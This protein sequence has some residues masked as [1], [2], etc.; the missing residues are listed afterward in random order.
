MERFTV[1][2]YF[3]YN[4]CVTTTVFRHRG[5]N[6]DKDELTDLKIFERDPRWYTFARVDIVGDKSDII[7]CVEQS[8]GRADKTTTYNAN[9]DWIR[10]HFRK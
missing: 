3:F 8:S 2:N 1:L 6:T 9:I 4:A 5:R 7:N 10:R